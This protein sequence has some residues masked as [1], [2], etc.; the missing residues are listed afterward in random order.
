MSQLTQVAGNFKPRFAALA[1]L[2]FDAV[3]GQRQPSGLQRFLQPAFG[4][5]GLG[6]EIDAAHALG[7]QPAHHRFGG[8]K[9]GIQT[10]GGKQRFE[11]V[12]QYRRPRAAAA[13]HLARAQIQRFAQLHFARQRRQRVLIDQIGAQPR[14]LAFGQ[15]GKGV[16]QHPR[17]GV[18]QNAVADKLQ[19]LVVQSGM[20]A[21]GQR[22]PQQGFVGKR[23]ADLPLDAGQGGGF[24]RVGFHKAA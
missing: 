8:G 5:F 3:F 2:F 10:H 13:F 19:P 15:L 16:V 24:A 6:V 18:I 9:T 23:V 21:V 20:A 17:H 22:L 4:V 1:G 11:R 12:G 14:Q 7:K